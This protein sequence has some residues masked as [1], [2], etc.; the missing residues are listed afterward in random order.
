MTIVRLLPLSL[1][2]LALGACTA[3]AQNRTE[4][5]MIGVQTVRNIHVNGTGEAKAPSDEA[6]LDVAVETEG[7]TAKAGGETPTPS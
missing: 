5:S 6:F 3:S 4:A 7:K 2:I 1:S